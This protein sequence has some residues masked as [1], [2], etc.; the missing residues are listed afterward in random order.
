MHRTLFAQQQR[1]QDE[2]S[3][4]PGISDP[5]N[6]KSSRSMENHHC[7]DGRAAEENGFQTGIN[8]TSNC[9][10]VH[11][12]C[13]S[14]RSVEDNTRGGLETEV[15]NLLLWEPR[16][17][18][19][20]TLNDKCEAIF[21]I[22]SSTQGHV[23]PSVMSIVKDWTTANNSEQCIESRRGQRELQGNDQCEELIAKIILL[24]LELKRL[25]NAVHS[26][27]HFTAAESKPKVSKE[28]KI[29]DYTFLKH[30]NYY[31]IERLEVKVDECASNCATYCRERDVWVQVD[32]RTIKWTKRR[33]C[34][35]TRAIAASAT[36]ASQP[37]HHCHICG[38]SVV[39]KDDADVKV[40][41]NYVNGVC[42]KVTCRRCVIVYVDRDCG[43]LG[44]DV[45]RDMRWTCS[46]CRNA[47]VR[48]LPFEPGQEWDLNA[49]EKYGARC[50]RYARDNRIRRISKILSNLKLFKSQIMNLS[51]QFA[52]DEHS[53]EHHPPS[54]KRRRKLF[55]DTV[56][57][58][59]IQSCVDLEKDG[60][61]KIP[62]LD[63]FPATQPHVTPNLLV[64]DDKILPPDHF[65]RTQPLVTTKCAG[66]F[67][68]L[69]PPVGLLNTAND[70]HCQEWAYRGLTDVDKPVV[71]VDLMCV[72]GDRTWGK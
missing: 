40:C 52:R 19:I 67:P 8:E 32:G 26:A 15:S 27:Q 9:E 46:H 68:Q 56:H 36:A 21:S 41:G 37:S 65:P 20:S 57:T 17:V 33:F 28:K 34:Q 43:V 1:T 35:G 2:S 61:D 62:T 29:G 18:N 64:E 24:E 25:E 69:L 60:G 71:D 5:N 30:L 11:S 58:R 72:D 48:P 49:V 7:E 23:P 44:D 39:A 6:R 3:V 14:K 50:F 16:Y 51:N 31:V 38:S 10:I 70:L 66:V 13:G 45:M 22:G 59:S 12:L 53:P 63:P 55:T 54:P 4:H 42:R 47:C